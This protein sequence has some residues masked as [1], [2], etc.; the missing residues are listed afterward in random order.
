MDFA[1]STQ[2]EKL[3]REIIQQARE[4]L[5]QDIRQRDKDG[6]FDRSLWHRCGE[7]NLAGLAVPV[8]FGG[9]GLDALTTAMALDALGYG[10]EDGGLI[11][12]LSAHNLACLVPIWKHGSDEQQRALL[13]RLSSGEW[14][15]AV[16]MTEQASGSDV[17]SIVTTALEAGESYCLNGSK[18]LITNAPVADVAI[19][20]A[21][22]DPSKGFHGGITAF[23]VELNS[24]GVVRGTRIDASSVRTCDVGDLTFQDVV[25]PKRCVLGSVG[26]GAS[27]FNTAMDWERSCLFA[28][29][30]GTMERV[31]EYALRHAR[32]RRQGGQSIGKFQAVA[33]RIVDMKV[34][35]EAARLLVYRAAW[36]LDHCRT[37]SLDTAMAKLFASESLFEAALGAVR[38]YGGSGLMVENDLERALRDSVACLLYSGTSD[39]QRNIIARWLGL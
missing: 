6:T 10:C 36:R 38:T 12:A 4:H 15:A 2:Q 16:A 31:L 26:G 39:I 30:V 8:E 27:V 7:L 5:N 3:R 28:A 19:V 13:P 1:P 37:A 23:L 32:T 9:R 22:T 18:T 25:V 11:F 29:H 33:H 35:L 20:F 14:I 24:P 21:V 17:F 34:N